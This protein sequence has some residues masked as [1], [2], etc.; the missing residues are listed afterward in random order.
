M[1][2]SRM[3]WTVHVSLMEEKR[4]ECRV[5]VGKPEGKNPLARSRR[6]WESKFRSDLRGLG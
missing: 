4:K 2:N 5:L 3:R 6:R 1:S